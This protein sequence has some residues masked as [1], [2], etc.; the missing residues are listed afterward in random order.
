MNKK[1]LSIIIFIGITVSSSAQETSADSLAKK[2]QKTQVS[3]PDDLD[4]LDDISFDELASFLDSLLMPHSYFLA[5]LQVGKGFYNY[6]SKS[7]YLLQTT[8]KLTY[9]PL[10]GYY[11]KSGLGITASGYLLNDDHHALNFFQGAI[12]PSYDYLE[13]K[14][15]ATGINYTRYFTKDSLPFYT[16]PLQNELSAYFTWRK[17]WIKPSL[18]ATYGWGSRTAYQQRE[19]LINSLRLRPRGYT[20]INSTESVKDFSLLVSVRHDF[21]WLDVLK[22]ND[23]IRVTPQLAYSSGTQKFG[24]NQTSNTYVTTLRTGTNI[25]YSSRSSFL[26]D[27][28]KFQPLSLT[29]FL[30]TE[31]AIGKFFIQPQLIFDYYFPATE[32]NFST[33]FSLNTGFML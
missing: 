14:N 23:H 7:T 12:S 32:N 28:T 9:S 6:E 21:Y 11:H 24:F 10:I 3:V 19:K 16:S 1:W 33:I 2:A 4:D 30:R 31:Y 18:T 15:L 25:L 13:N 17:W 5:S 29:F 26:D 8:K 22:Y 20:R 27:Q